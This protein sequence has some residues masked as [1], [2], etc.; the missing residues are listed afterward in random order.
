M[1]Q[2]LFKIQIISITMFCCYQGQSQTK[3]TSVDVGQ[4]KLHFNIIKGKGI[5]ILFESGSG[6]DGSVGNTK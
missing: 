5:P 4:Y 6:N 2:I 1:K 3:D